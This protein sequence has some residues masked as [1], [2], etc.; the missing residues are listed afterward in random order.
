MLFNYLLFDSLIED[1]THAMSKV[2][3]VSILVVVRKNNRSMVEQ[4]Q[5]HIYIMSQ[6]LWFR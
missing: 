3:G 6:Y 5:T 2:T 1:T 4:S